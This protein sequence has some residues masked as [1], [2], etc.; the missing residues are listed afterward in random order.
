M[1]SHT[2]RYVCFFFP[3]FVI[4]FFQDRDSQLCVDDPIINRSER[5]TSRSQSAREVSEID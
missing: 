4:S 2:A 5:K 1:F 3:F